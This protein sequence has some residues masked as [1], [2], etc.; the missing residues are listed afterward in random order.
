MTFAVNFAVFGSFIVYV[1]ALLL[2]EAN[3]WG[4][5]VGKLSRESRYSGCLLR[6]KTA[7]RGTDGES[8]QTSIR[9]A[10]RSLV[11]LFTEQR[12]V[13][14]KGTIVKRTEFHQDRCSIVCDGT[15]ELEKRKQTLPGR[16]SIRSRKILVPHP[17]CQICQGNL[18]D[19]HHLIFAV[20][21]LIHGSLFR[22]EIFQC[23]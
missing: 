2:G 13:A 18:A 7:T 4:G 3:L 1:G 23:T 21:Q 8:E 17:H 20:I 12:E 5:I 15:R 9:K 19:C 22:F 14:I 11:D 6:R 10:R 16:M